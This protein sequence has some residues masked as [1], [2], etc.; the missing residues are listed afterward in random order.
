MPP[1]RRGADAALSAWRAAECNGASGQELS[2]EEAKKLRKGPESV[3]KEREL[4]AWEQCKKFQQMEECAPSNST[5]DTRWAS[6]RKKVGGK[7]DA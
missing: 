4:D 2:G 3:A 5:V 7:K 1:Q 6:T